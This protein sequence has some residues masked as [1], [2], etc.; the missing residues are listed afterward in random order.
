MGW[1]VQHASGSCAWL[2]DR[3]RVDAPAAT[4]RRGHVRR[5]SVLLALA[6]VGCG[7]Q[8]LGET[9]SGAAP[10]AAVTDAIAI[11]DAGTDESSSCPASAIACAGTCASGRC[12]TRLADGWYGAIAVDDM[13]VYGYTS[14]T[15]ELLYPALTALPFDGGA[16]TI[17]NTMV[18][19]PEVVAVDPTRVYWFDPPAL[20]SMPLGG[21]APTTLAMATPT[22]GAPQP[23]SAFGIAGGYVVWAGANG[24]VTSLPVDGGVPIT[25]YTTGSVLTLPLAATTTDVFWAQPISGETPN[26]IVRAPLAGGAVT[27]VMTGAYQYGPLAADATNLYWVASDSG[28]GPGHL[29]KMPLAGGTPVTLSTASSLLGS[30]SMVVEDDGSVLLVAGIVATLSQL[31]RVPASGAAPE[32]VAQMFGIYGLAVD[33]TSI[34]FTALLPPD[35]GS[36][37]PQLGALFKV[38]PK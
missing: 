37:Y 9:P 35:G 19:L 26:E 30:W 17:L 3:V 5:L 22:T 21:G 29:V 7:G 38:T 31:L 16:A 28:Q 14:P 32:V 8:V 33:A 10:D 6:S 12:T 18:S 24:L 2:S 11:A 34:Y 20:L 36:A 4:C 25:Q 23:Q 27:T 1:L 15:A 13:G